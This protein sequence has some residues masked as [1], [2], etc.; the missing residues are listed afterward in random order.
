MTDEQRFILDIAGLRLALRCPQTK[1]IRGLFA[2][3]HRFHSHLEAEV[4]VV[5][6]RHALALSDQELRFDN[7]VLR[8]TAPGYDGAV[9][10][11]RGRAWLHLPPDNPADDIEY[12]LRLCTALLAFERGALLFHAAGLVRRGR[13]YLFFGHSGSGK[14]TVARLSPDA[15]VLNDDLVLLRRERGEWHAYST[16]F[17]NPTQ[18]RPANVAKA[19]LRALFRLVQD[20]KVHLE[21]LPKAKALAELIASTPV[22]PADPQRLPRL[23]AFHQRLLADVP[24]YDLHFLPDPS[25]WTVIDDLGSSACNRGQGTRWDFVPE[26][27]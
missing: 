1:L 18:M 16:P 9:D 25:F 14:T 2:R 7:G 21:P 12:F 24:I 6:Q 23:L 13:G 20:T 22:I 19:P 3:Y 15:E 10:V 17:W 27:E 4:Q 8:F 5:G 11:K 26:E